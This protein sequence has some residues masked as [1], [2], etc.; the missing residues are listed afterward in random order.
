M[1]SGDEGGRETLGMI[2]GGGVKGRE[3]LGMILRAE[4]AV[5]LRT[6]WTVLRT[7]VCSN[8]ID[9]FHLCDTGGM[10]GWES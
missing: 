10:K 7:P 2:Q 1:I 8:P 5:E 4:G 9:V 3:S 6:P